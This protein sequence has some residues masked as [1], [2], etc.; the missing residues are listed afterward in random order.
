MLRG[1]GAKDVAVR[2]AQREEPDQGH[3]D[4]REG[5]G[6]G[7]DE[8]CVID[9]LAVG[10]AEAASTNAGPGRES[11]SG[12]QDDEKYCHQNPQKETSKYASSSCYQCNPA[13]VRCC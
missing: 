9:V 11:D 8:T 1:S 12:D 7:I 5:S 4:Q 10:G 2:D 3:Q 6:A 13:Q